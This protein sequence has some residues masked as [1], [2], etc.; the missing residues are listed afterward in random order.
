MTLESIAPMSDNTTVELPDMAAYRPFPPDTAMAARLL[1]HGS[2]HDPDKLRSRSG[3]TDDGVT[4]VDRVLGGSPPLLAINP[5]ASASELSEQRGFAHLVRGTFAMFRNPTA[6][7]ARIHWIMTKEDA[8]DL[9]TVVSL[10]H[11]RLDKAHM[12]ARL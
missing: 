8:E 9:L 2:G 12:P 3:L 1:H 7:E 6:H 10:I 11:R 4:L 5:Q